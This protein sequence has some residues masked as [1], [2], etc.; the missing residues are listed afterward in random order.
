MST[1]K[2]YFNDDDN[3]KEAV[4]EKLSDLCTPSYQVEFDPLEAE[5]VGAFIEDSMTEEDALNSSTDAING[6]E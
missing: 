5:Q 6:M 3:A 4:K 1:E 2:I